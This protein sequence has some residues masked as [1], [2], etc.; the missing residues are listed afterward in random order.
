MTKRK[1]ENLIER[2]DEAAQAYALRGCQHPEDVPGIE[3]EYERAREAL[4]AALL[5]A[6]KGEQ[7]DG[8]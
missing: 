2:F 4:L 5:A 6:L 7:S 8:R 1:A 3:R